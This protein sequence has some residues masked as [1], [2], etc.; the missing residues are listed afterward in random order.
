MIT[1]SNKTA[2]LACCNRQQFNAALQHRESLSRQ[3][4]IVV[5]NNTSNIAS[6][7]TAIPSLAIDAI[8]ADSWQQVN[9][10]LIAKAIAEFSHERILEPVAALPAGHFTIDSDDGQVIYRFCA[11]LMALNHWHIAPESIEKIAQGKNSMLDA[12]D[13]IIEFKGQLAIDSKMLPTYLE[14]ITSTLCSSAFK[15]QQPWQ[16]S[17]VLATADFQQLEAAM[18]E[19]HPCFIANNGRIGFDAA[20][21]RAY[22]PEAGQPI[23]LIWL[24]ADKQRATFSATAEIDYSQLLEQELD[25]ITRQ[26]FKQQLLDRQLDPDNYLWIPV[27]P[28]QWFNK[29]SNVY[30]AEIAN[31]SLVL[32]GYGDD[33]YQ[34]QQSI[35]TFYNTSQ[36][37]KYYVKTALSILNMGFVRGLSAF[38]MRS[39][40]AINQWL[41]QLIDNDD[42]LQNKNFDMIAELAAVGYEHPQFSKQ[43]LGDNPYRKMLAALWRENP[44]N[45]L[46]P[47]QRLMTMAS[48]LHID[49]D[50][51]ALLPALIAT[52]PLSVEDWLG[53]YL[54]V[55]LSPLLH[56]FYRYKLAFMPHGENVILVLENNVPVSAIMKDIGE[57]ICLQNSDQSLPAAV[58]RIKIEAAEEIEVLAIFT[59]IFDCFLRFMSPILQQQAGLNEDVFWRCVADCI[60]DYQQDNP[61]LKPDFERHDLFASHFPLSCLNRLQLRNNQQMVD[62]TDPANSLSFAGSLDNPIAVYRPGHGVDAADSQRC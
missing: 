31:Q 24:A 50:G 29:L 43:K 36:P 4:N 41:R 34:A 60:A 37:S 40:P 7:M 54:D 53:Q 51:D 17:K 30:A 47:G 3:G 32:L 23:Q 49:A 56:C 14:E 16:P 42:Y 9:R 44:S 19:G 10:H 33:N 52:S 1:L 6:T 18:T 12:V 11:Q 25:I 21:Y 26:Q 45:R 46:K 59:D 27:H 2:Y 22:A 20:D 58:E 61:Q 13:F 35:R 55:Y 8:N 15:R 39:T 48:L 57:E 28:W 38:Y 62:L 5:G